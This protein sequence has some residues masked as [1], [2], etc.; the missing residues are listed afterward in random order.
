MK[1]IDLLSAPGKVNNEDIVSY[2]ADYIILLDGATG[3][4]NNYLKDYPTDAIWFVQEVVKYI[5]HNI[6]KYPDILK[7]LA[8]LIDY[9][10]KVY[11]E[12]VLKTVPKIDLPSAGMILVK[13]LAE[14]VEVLMLGDCTTII[15]DNSH[16][17]KVLH[18]SRISKLDAG[19]IEKMKHVAKD[20]KL[21]LF[22]TRDFVL[23][24]LITNRKKK[25]TKTG[26]SVLGFEHVDKNNLIY[27]KFN[28][29][30]L[31]RIAIFS[32]GIAEYYETLLLAKDALEFYDLLLTKGAKQI[33][34][35]IRQTQDFDSTC[36]NFPRLKPKDDASVAVIEF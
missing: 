30:N 34:F 2:G 21:P 18:D 27:R 14:T 1:I 8:K 10:N 33:L 23:E 11:K 7:L 6:N 4:T 22:K 36:D 19:V 29:N 5:D 3:L 26:Y 12:L 28:K 16:E 24:D 17:L 15:E 20:K 9:L 31:K 25:N 35:E 32:D 13:E